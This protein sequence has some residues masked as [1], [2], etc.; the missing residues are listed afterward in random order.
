M[1]AGGK[2]AAGASLILEE[3][4]EGSVAAGETIGLA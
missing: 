1:G 4:W 3:L 2:A